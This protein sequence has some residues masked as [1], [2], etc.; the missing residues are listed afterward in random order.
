ME[1]TENPAPAKRHPFLHDLAEDVALVTNA[2][3][4]HVNGRKQVLRIVT[5]GARLYESQT[6]TYL[7]TVDETRTLF[8][9][10]AELVGG[11]QVHG[12]V[13]I[14]KNAAGEV[15]HLNIGFSPLDSALS[16]AVRLGE[17]IEAEA[18]DDG[19]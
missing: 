13:V 1:T 5:S 17:L 11:R 2:L 3:S 10:D 8:E 18:I 16:F 7:K 6:P 12:V 9:Y 15:T 4:T 14:D 19:K